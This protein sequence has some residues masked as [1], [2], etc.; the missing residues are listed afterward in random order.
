MNMF[1]LESE[2]ESESQPIVKVSETAIDIC[3]SSFKYLQLAQIKFSVFHNIAA[4]MTIDV[5]TCGMMP[6]PLVLCLKF[7]GL[8]IFEI[9]GHSS[10]T[11]I[12]VNVSN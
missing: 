4:L 9:I 6:R 11:I 2:S 5:E 8:C 12:L 10:K 3:M 7:V 1:I